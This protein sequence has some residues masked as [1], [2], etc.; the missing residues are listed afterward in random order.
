[1]PT[2]DQMDP[3]APIRAVNDLAQTLETIGC[4][5]V[6][7]LVIL[8]AYKM[9]RRRGNWL[10]MCVPLAAAIN[11]FN[12]PLF[13]DGYHL[14][15]Y[16]PGQWKLFST[17]GYPLPVWVMAAYIVVY[18]TPALFIMQQTERGKSREWVYKFFGVASL[19]VATWESLAIY[20]GTYTY[21]G[22][23]PFRAGKYPAWLGL[24]EG[25]HM[26][27][28][29]ILLAALTPILI[30][31]VRPLLAVPIFGISFCSVMFAAG[32]PGLAVTNAD[33]MPTWGLYVGATASMALACVTV[34]LAAQ[35][36]PSE[37]GSGREVST[38]MRSIADK[39]T[40]ASATR[41][42]LAQRTVDRDAAATRHTTIN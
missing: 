28:W 19:G 42:G 5:A 16:G 27:T 17:F 21:Y 3:L 13:D 41:D 33:P 22:D 38:L 34:W 4:W 29:G 25:A 12:E 20:A 24:M 9:S 39:L 11:S 6:A 15:W 8:W 1:M 10:P 36:L 2:I 23:H 30:K 32:A 31:G 14:F 7:G 37:R 26:V 40:A 18:A 35:L